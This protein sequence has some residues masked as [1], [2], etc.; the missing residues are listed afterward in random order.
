ME[1]EV[2]N[3]SPEKKKDNLAIASLIVSIV[4]IA[5]SWIP[6]LNIISMVVAIVG[7]ILGAWSL[8]RAIKNKFPVG[9]AITSIIVSLFSI[10]LISYM[11]TNLNSSSSS[12]KVSSSTAQSSTDSTSNTTESKTDSNNS[13]PEEK[14]EYNVGET[15][16]FDG[17]EVTVT[18]VKRNYNTGNNFFT[19]KSGNEFVKV[20]IKI[21]NTSESEASINSLDFKIQNSKGVIS[22]CSIVTGDSAED[23]L[24]FSTLAPGGTTEGAVIFEVPKNDS[25]LKLIYNPSFFSNRK[26]TIKL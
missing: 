5:G 6:I 20:Y 2:Q 15:I 24:S 25:E 3:S 10:Y 16:D 22:S 7:I 17:K 19:P 12:K 9:K 26:V 1:N 13:A 4:A 18:K 8:I 11:Y 14:S 21:V 23:E